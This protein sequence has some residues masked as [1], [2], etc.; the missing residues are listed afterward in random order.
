MVPLRLLEL[1]V[2]H[3]EKTLLLN[4]RKEGESQVASEGGAATGLHWFVM[5]TLYTQLF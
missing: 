3:T 5:G 4:C 1:G 2:S